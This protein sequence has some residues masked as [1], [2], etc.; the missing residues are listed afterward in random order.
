MGGL[1]WLV[2]LSISFFQHEG[3]DVVRAVIVFMLLVIAGAAVGIV[4]K[5]AGSWTRLPLNL[6]S[7]TSPSVVLAGDRRTAIAISVGLAAF[8]GIISMSIGIAKGVVTGIAGRIGLGIL[9]GVLAGAT[10]GV[11]LSFAITAWPLYGTARTWLALRHR[12]PR[13]SSKSGLTVRD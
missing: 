11:I 6:S 4:L 9:N 10:A 8:F 12:L 1:L 7:A 2:G 3:V 13:D 5:F